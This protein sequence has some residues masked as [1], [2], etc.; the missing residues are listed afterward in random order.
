MPKYTITVNNKKQTVE[1][2]EG[3]PLLWV[4]RDSLGLTGTKYGCGEGICGSCVVHI[5]GK[6]ECSCILNIE[7]IGNSPVT[8]IEGLAEN[9]D[10][11]VFKKWVELE[12]SQCGYCQPGVIMQVAGLLS[13]SQAPNAED[14]IDEMDDVVCRC[15]TY[16][17][18]KQGIKTAVQIMRKE[19]TSS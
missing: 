15:G 7:D 3:T 13:K 8:T 9:P 1:V 17:R 6:A 5:D 12:V 18:M 19:G 16:H 10:H 2:D 14:V 11:P 4:L